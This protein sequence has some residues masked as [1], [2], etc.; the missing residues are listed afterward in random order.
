LTEQLQEYA[1]VAGEDVVDHLRQ[2]CAPL[3]GMC[4]V[5]VNSTRVGGGVAEILRKLVPLK[6]ELGIDANW[7]VIEGPRGFFS[8]T[9]P[10]S[11]TRPAG[12]GSG[13]GAAT[14]T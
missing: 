13:S 11:R 9:R 5:H 2:L 6:R 10:S 1:N 4:V 7:E 14:S 8:T 3:K 12:P